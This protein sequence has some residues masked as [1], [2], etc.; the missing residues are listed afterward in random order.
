MTSTSNP[1]TP[2]DDRQVCIPQIFANHAVNL[3]D[4]P[5]I[6]CREQTRKWKDFDANMSR[7]ANA[8]LGL[9]IGRGH[10]VAVLMDSSI[11]IIEVMFGIVRAGA[12][13]VP[14]SGLLTSDQIK[15]LL[16]DSGPMAL[17]C[18]NSQKAKVDECRAQL[19]TLHSN[20]LFAT[21][22][23]ASDWRSF[24]EMMQG[25]STDFPAVEYQQD[26]PFNIIY[27][28]GTTGLPKGIVQTHRAR[29][30]W[31]FSNAID[32]CFHVNA[33]GLTSTALYSNGTWLTMLP[34][35]FVGGTLF[36]MPEF[37]ASLFLDLIQKHA[38]THTF[39][40]PTQLIMCLA[41]PTD[42]DRDLSSLQSVLCAGSTLRSEVRQ[43]VLQK[44]TP[45]LYY[46]Y[47]F[48]EG[49]ATMCKPD[50]HARKSESVGLPVLGFEVM[51]VDDA[52]RELSRGETGEI[53]GY[54][55]GLMKTYHNREALTSESIVLDRRGRTFFRSGD[56]GRIDADGFL[57]VV[58]RKKDMIISG[59][60]NIFPMDLEAIAGGHEDVLDVSVIAVPDPKWGETPLALVIPRREDADANA[61]REWANARLAKHQRIS[62]VVL[63][64][65]LPRNA[66]G[67]VLKRVLRAHF[68]NDAVANQG[69]V[70]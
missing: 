27:S 44:L 32:L 2:L 7:I 9:G 13:V 19:S 45:N 18:A 21:D 46:M 35:L 14:L 41:E 37:T 17:F 1:T 34:T 29:L 15:T 40:V 8:L 5:A 16:N 25:A 51:I 47:G 60:F 3:A 11:E 66:L 38:I 10:K 12:C 55:A 53:A 39:T 23:Q 52:G 69:R 33:K 65:D 64:E 59:G 6:V 68:A 57:Y 43:E 63:V 42:P 36:V 24:N 4:K 61:I 26:D 56:V 58:D 31:A 22:F 30:H 28:S 54:G 49:F 48:S 62:R 20:Y 67:K 50:Q 70:G